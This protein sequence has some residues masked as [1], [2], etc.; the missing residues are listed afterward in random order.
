LGPI[1][2]QCVVNQNQG[3]Q[4]LFDALVAAISLVIKMQVQCLVP[5][6]S[7]TQD[8]DAKA[9]GNCSF[10]LPFLLLSF[11][12]CKVHNMLNMMLDPRFKGLG[13]VV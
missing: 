2:I 6:S 10:G 13:L 7:K 11:Q 5:D 12:E 9:S 3:Y 8:F 4:L 1:V